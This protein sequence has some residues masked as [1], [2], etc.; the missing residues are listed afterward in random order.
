MFTSAPNMV[1]IS[2]IAAELWRFSFSAILDFVTGQKWRNSTLPRRTVHVYHRA[3]FGH[4]ITNGGRD[5]AIFRF[6]K[7][8]PAAILDFG[9]TKK[10]HHGKLR[11]ESADHGHQHTKFGEYIW[12][13]GWVMAIFLFPIWR[14][15]AIL[16]F[17][18]GQEWRYGTFRTAHVYH[19]AKS[20]DNSSNGGRVIAIFRFSKWRP[21]ASFDFVVAQKWRHRTLRAVHGYPHTKFGEHNSK[22]GWVMAIFL[23]PKW[24]SAAILDLARPTYWSTLDGALV[25]LGVLSNFVLIWLIV[26]KILKIQFFLRLAWNCLTTPTFGGFMGLWYPET[27]LFLIETLKRHI[28]G[29]AASFKV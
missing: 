13:S 27:I 12:N 21:T 17:V 5:I 24:R 9:V 6:S 4:N 15:S 3:K 10:W 16:D 2:E 22:S 7:W 8:R 23:F 28:M 20:G 14:P 26:L 19:H 11:A 29:E 18:T 1:K 25:V